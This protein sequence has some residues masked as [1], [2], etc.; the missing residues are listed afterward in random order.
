LS[1]TLIGNYLSELARLRQ[2]SG[3]R[4]ESVLREAFKD[5]L[6]AWGRQHDLVFVPEYELDTATKDRRYVDGALLHDPVYRDKYALNLKRE[7]PRV[8]LYGSLRADFWRWADWGRELMELHIGY[9]AVEPWP[10][11]RTDT[12]DDKARAAGQAPRCI[13]KSEPEAGRIVIDS[14]T[15]LAGVPHEA[16]G[17]RLGNRCAIDWV[18]DQHKEKKP[19]DPTIREKFD[20]YRFADHKQRVIDLLARVVRVSVETLRVVHELKAAPR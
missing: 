20:T 7:F 14:E 4:R 16:W 18:L 19:R 12:P 1:Q 17:Y 15:V 10:L 6:K 11:A 2:A 9:E 5:L 13:L 3:S 8:P